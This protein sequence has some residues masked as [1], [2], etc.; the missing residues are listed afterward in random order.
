MNQD[1]VRCHLARLGLIIRKQPLDAV[2]IQLVIAIKVLD[3][4]SE[5][6][7][8]II[9]QD[10]LPINSH[11]I[12]SRNH[13]DFREVL[14]H[15]IHVPVMRPE[16]VIGSYVFKFNYSFVQAYFFS[17]KIKRSGLLKYYYLIRFVL[18]K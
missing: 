9:K 8:E 13:L 4:L 1:L 17:V 5:P 12:A 6:L 15:Q 10:R 16:K 18:Q 11:L 7:F 14:F 3:Q 2:V